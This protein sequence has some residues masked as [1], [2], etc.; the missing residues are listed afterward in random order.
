MLVFDELWPGGPKFAQRKGV[1]M[2]STDSVLLADFVNMVKVRRCADLGCG[3]GV[4]SVLLAVK[5]RG[6]F[7]DG[8][9]IQE[10][11]AA[12]CR[13][14]LKANGLD[15]RVRVIE[16]DLREHRKL[17]KAGAYDLVVSNPPYFPVG[18]GGQS[19]VE[20]R[21]LA[22]SESMCTFSDLC[23]AAAYLCRFGGSF[24][25]VHRPERLSEVFCAMTQAGI[26]PKRLRL[27]SGRAQSPPSLALIEG[28]RGGN[29]GLVIE[30]P[31]VMYD[32]NGDYTR[33]MNRIY[34]R[35]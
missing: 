28:R 17:L 6:A 34:H 20:E 22:R 19:P 15:G 32:E 21:D 13:E 26:E 23:Q 1:F 10:D 9:E 31:L 30:P 29:P 25:L 4:L 3:S 11:S 14:N 8:V 24:A 7:I 12:L 35:F 18:R 33:E 2:L 16:G 5:N 27:V